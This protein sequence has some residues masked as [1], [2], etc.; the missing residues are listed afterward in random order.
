MLD[1]VFD[2]GHGGKDPGAIGPT[3]KNEA[4]FVLDICLKAGSYVK[5]Q[6]YTVGYTRTNDKFLELYERANI[7]NSLK[8]KYFVSFHINSF[9]DPSVN[10]LE[11]Y[12]Y[13]KGGAGEIL[14]VNILEE[15]LPVMDIPNRGVKTANFAVLRRTQAPAAL[16]ELGFM[17]NPEQESKLSLETYRNELAIAIAKGCIETLGGNYKEQPVFT[18]V[19]ETKPNYDYVE[20]QKELNIQGYGKLAIDNIPGPK[21]LAACPTVRIGARGNITKWIQK[22]LGISADG[23]F[24]EKTKK[25]VIDFQKTNGLVSDGILGKNTWRKLLGL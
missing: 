22:R 3:R 14:A 12:C 18:P 6:G 1:F 9:T 21:T 7:S 24:G 19:Q 10:G 25:A 16:L 5:E 13:S 17:S 8:P 15:L 23:I 4:D 11:T 20:L 2:A